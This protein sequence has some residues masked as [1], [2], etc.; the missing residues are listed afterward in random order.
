MA[1]YFNVNSQIKEE[2][3]ERREKER[4]KRYE[5]KLSVLKD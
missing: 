5:E 1:V 2:A 4:M 3:R